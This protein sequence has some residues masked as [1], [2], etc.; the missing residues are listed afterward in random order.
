M[1]P[2]S[3]IM[4][5]RLKIIT[6]LKVNGKVLIRKEFADDVFSSLEMV[7]GILIDEIY[8][9]CKSNSIVTPVANIPETNPIR[10]SWVNI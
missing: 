9:C 7:K 6:F 3:S 1:I 2:N 5:N 4:I 8:D 10:T